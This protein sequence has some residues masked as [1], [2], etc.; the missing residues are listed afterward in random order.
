[1]SFQKKVDQLNVWSRGDERAPHKPLLLLLILGRHA[2]ALPDEVSF[3]EIEKELKG[4]LVE[5]GPPRQ[6]IHHEYPFWY[7]RNDGIWKVTSDV[8]LRPR[9][10]NAGIP[11]SEL[12]KKNARGRLPRSVL[13]ELEKRPKLIREVAQSILDSHFPDSLHDDIA[14]AVGLAFKS[15][16]RRRRDPHFRGKVLMAYEYRCA[17]CG[18]DV[19]LG[20]VTIGLEAA[21]IKWHQA[22]GPDTEENGLALCATHH[23]LFDFG[24][25]SFTDS[26]IIILS[27]QLNGSGKFRDRVLKH[28]GTPMRPPQDPAHVPSKEYVSWHR[29]QVFKEPARAL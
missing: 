29:K 8:P 9:K 13:D 16:L 25:L 23:K 22:N 17:F 3:A 15:G 24:A 19:R 14:A 10:S 27:K 6:S 11:V 1:M 2:R 7:L 4:L 5:F 21:H 12:R 26:G 28:H 20:N 18:L